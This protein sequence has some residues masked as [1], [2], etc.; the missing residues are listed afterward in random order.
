MI[1]LDMDGVFADFDGHYERH[2]GYRPTRW[3]MED[4]TDWKLIKSVPNFYITIPV[5][6]GARDLFRYVDE[7]GEGCAFLTGVPVSISESANEKTEWGR[8][9]FPDVQVV[10]CPAKDKWRHGQPGDTLIDDYLRY[11]V[12]WTDMGGVFIHHTSVPSTIAQL[13]EWGKCA[14]SSWEASQPL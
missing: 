13:R 11:R 3:P 6:P 5:M 4:T 12:D 9:N 14:L 1:W 8:I 7:V 10:C 2:F